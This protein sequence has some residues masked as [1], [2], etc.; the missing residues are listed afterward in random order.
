MT[1]AAAR[2]LANVRKMALRLPDTNERASHGTPTFFIRDKKTFAMFWDGHHDDART[3]LWLAAPPGAQQ[4][5][6]ATG[7]PRFFRPP[8]VGPRGWIGVVLDARSDWNEIDGLVLDAFVH[9]APRKLVAALD[10]DR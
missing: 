4:A 8:Y 5:L 10:L 6:I 3:V 1:A 7:A 2:A 9:V